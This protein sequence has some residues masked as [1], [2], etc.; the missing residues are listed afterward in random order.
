MIF[1][2]EKGG[3]GP[4]Y[5]AEHRDMYE[6]H[7]YSSHHPGARTDVKGWR[8]GML[9]GFQSAKHMRRWFGKYLRE[10]LYMG[11]KVKKFKIKKKHVLFSTSG[12]QIAFDRRNVLW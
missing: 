10:L 2:V 1:R 4:Y 9:S 12:K 5:V 11:Y 8:C 6:A 3:T 7:S